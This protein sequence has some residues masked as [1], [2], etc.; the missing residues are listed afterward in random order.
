MPECVVSSPSSSEDTEVASPDSKV[1]HLRCHYRCFA[2]CRNRKNKEVMCGKSEKEKDNRL[3]RDPRT[4]K[5]KRQREGPKREAEHV[6]QERADLKAGQ[7]TRAKRKNMK[8]RS[9]LQTGIETRGSQL[10]HKIA[11]VAETE[12]GIQEHA[13]RTNTQGGIETKGSQLTGAMRAQ[14][15]RT[16]RK[17]HS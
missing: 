8:T 12:L 2:Q 14:R 1:W 5:R 9:V 6:R 10:E 11:R 3:G 16:P 4:P 15:S 17:G 7:R 13:E